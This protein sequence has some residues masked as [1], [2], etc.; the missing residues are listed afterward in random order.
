MYLIVGLGNPGRQ[1]AGNRHNFG[2]MC[3]DA[4]A[5]SLGL[6]FGQRRARAL[7]A[8]GRLGEASLLLAKPQ[9]YTNLSGQS[10]AELVR[11]YRIPLTNLLAVHDDLDLPLGRI[12]L[13]ERGSSGGHKGLQSIIGCLRTDEFPRLRLGIGRPIE[14]PPEVYVLRDFAPDEKPIVAATVDK[15]TEAIKVFVTDGIAVAMNR[16]NAP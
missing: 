3:L 14:E 16:F 2:F 7:V 6:R 13:R 15:A 11:F 5:S 4:L 10:V 12:R 8:A 9:T 1:Y